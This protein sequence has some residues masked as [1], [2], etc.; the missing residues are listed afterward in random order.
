MKGW[1]CRIVLIL[2]LGVATAAGANPIPPPSDANMP[3]ED[4]YAELIPIK[5][6][7]G[8]EETFQ[9]GFYFDEIPDTV[10]LIKFPVPPETRGFKVA[11]GKLPLEWQFSDAIIPHLH[12][13]LPEMFPLDWTVLRE[14]YPTILPEWPWIP[15]HGWWAPGG[16]PFPPKALFSVK[17][18]HDV[19]KR[20][21][22][23]VY[24]Y[25]LGCGKQYPVPDVADA[26]AAPPDDVPFYRRGVTSFLDITMPLSLNVA[27]MSL[28]YTPHPFAVTREGDK[29]VVSFYAKT[30]FGPFK[31]DLIAIIR[32]WWIAADVNYDDSTDILDLIAVR[33]KLGSDLS[34]EESEDADINGDGKINVL[35]LI[36]VRDHIGEKA[37]VDLALPRQIRL[38]YKVK[39]CGTTQ[40][41]GIKPDVIARGRRM[42]V[43][44]QIYFNCCPEYVRMAIL[45]DGDAVVFR[46]KAMEEAPCDCN[47]YYPMRGIAGPFAPGVYRV[48]ILNPY[49]KVILEKEVEIN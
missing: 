49:G 32:P 23:Y 29:T 12:E 11:I 37:E 25:A 41:P 39:E 30:E 9:G 22:S 17:Y 24:F 21:C 42:I 19:L 13:N 28:D 8:L 5:G 31:R 27:R 43:T 38:R 44:D 10:R 33:N 14:L 48:K 4:M 2:A 46:E 7:T 15:V 34:D 6:G 16:D 3:L 47:C 45:V 35:D 36:A 26:D 20:G 40:P 1:K 18:Q